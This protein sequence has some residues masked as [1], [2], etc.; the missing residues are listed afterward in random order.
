MRGVGSHRFNI[1]QVARRRRGIRVG[2][3]S[4]LSGVRLAGRGGSTCRCR[5][6]RLVSGCRRPSWRRSWRGCRQFD[7]YC[8]SGGR[9]NLVGRGRLCGLFIAASGYTQQR[10]RRGNDD[11]PSTQYLCPTQDCFAALTFALTIPSSLGRTALC[12]FIPSMRS[13]I[14]TACPKGKQSPRI[15]NRMRGLSVCDR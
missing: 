14:W 12:P 3:W 8:R 15:L 11:Q 7:R 10:E 4:S 6:R 2:C 5:K 9:L 13:S 1:R